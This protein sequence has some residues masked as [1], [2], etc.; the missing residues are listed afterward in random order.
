MP[1]RCDSENYVADVN[2]SALCG[3]TDWRMP[4]AK[5]LSSIVTYGFAQ[6]VADPT[7]FPNTRSTAGTGYWSSLTSALDASSAW[8]VDF[9]RGD[10]EV[11]NYLYKPFSQKS[12]A[13]SV[14]LV[15]GSQ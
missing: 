5:E 11:L 4:T 8:W 14:R 13:R 10:V 15:R 2:T 12:N 7:F 9:M 3:F 6:P 1:G